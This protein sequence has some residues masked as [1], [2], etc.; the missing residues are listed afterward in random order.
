MSRKQPI[1]VYKYVNNE[2]VGNPKRFPQLTGKNGA[3]QYLRSQGCKF[4]DNL[5]TR[6]GDESIELPVNET[7]YFEAEC[8]AAPSQAV[9]RR[10]NGPVCE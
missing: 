1:V 7:T 2:I 3:K 5:F 6:L 10:T 9:R 8:D 4:P